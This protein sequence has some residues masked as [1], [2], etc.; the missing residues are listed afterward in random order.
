MGCLAPG[1]LIGDIEN[2]IAERGYISANEPACGSGAIVLGVAKV[3]E[4]NKLNYQKQ[5]YVE[6]C[7]I[8]IKCVHMTYLQLALCGIP[9]VVIHGD[10][11][12]QKEWS[13]WYT[14]MYMVDGWVWKIR[15]RT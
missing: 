4:E 11:L 6:A 2:E 1:I 5:L 14:P 15:K 10:S 8:D 12:T 13:R 9:A 3:M 7:D